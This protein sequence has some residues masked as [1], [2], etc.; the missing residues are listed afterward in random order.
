LL[1]GK[2]A[3]H[4][5]FITK[6]NKRKASSALYRRYLFVVFARKSWKDCFIKKVLAL[7]NSRRNRINKKGC[8]W[9]KNPFVGNKKKKLHKIIVVIVCCIIMMSFRHLCYN[10]PV[11]TMY[12]CLRADSNCLRFEFG[13]SGN[14]NCIQENDPAICCLG[15]SHQCVLVGLSCLMYF[16]IQLNY[17]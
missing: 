11:V 9:L 4:Y 8:K 14:P 1:T 2:A 17:P 5:V 12:L 13:K 3:P 7:V 16:P 15:M 10:G 6:K